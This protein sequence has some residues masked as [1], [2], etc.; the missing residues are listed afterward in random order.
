MSELP[1]F[2]APPVWTFD[3][4]DGRLIAG[5]REYKGRVFF[6]LRLWA[7]QHGDK[8]TQKGVTVPIEAV[9]SLADALAAY[10][11]GLPSSDA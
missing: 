1:G 3:K 7:G 6:E 2:T 11:A 9:G 10:A 8:A 5:E 4:Y